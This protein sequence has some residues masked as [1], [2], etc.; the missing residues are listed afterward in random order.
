MKYA[1]VKELVGGRRVACSLYVIWRSMRERCLC[2]T[3]RD[4]KYYGGRG[5]QVCARWSGK[6]G[7]KQFIEDMGR[8][9]FSRASPSLSR[10]PT[11]PMTV[12]PRCFA[13]WQARR[14]TP[15]A[16]A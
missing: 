4:Y 14:P 6:N 1:R 9:P 2:A 7:F 12:H 11:V 13:H 8:Q 3:Y 15:P 16:A 5:I 10:E